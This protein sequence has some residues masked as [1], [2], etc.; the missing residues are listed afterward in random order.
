MK[1]FFKILL[2]PQRPSD[3][4]KYGLNVLDPRVRSTGP[5]RGSEENDSR[6]KVA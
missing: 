3:R 5:T 2:S 4:K 1:V 6:V